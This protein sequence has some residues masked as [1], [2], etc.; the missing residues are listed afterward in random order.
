MLGLDAELDQSCPALF[1]RREVLASAVST[2]GANHGMGDIGKFTKFMRQLAAVSGNPSNRGGH[3]PPDRYSG[4]LRLVNG[5]QRYGVV[6]SS[7]AVLR[8]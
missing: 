3:D 2:L 6:T 1:I 5:N 4:E 8:D 7:N